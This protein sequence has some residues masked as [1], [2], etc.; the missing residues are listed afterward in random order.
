MY[1]E[2]PTEPVDK[3]DE[4]LVEDILEKRKRSEAHLAEWRKKAEIWYDMVAGK[5]WTAEDEAAHKDQRKPCVSFNRIAVMVNAI[6][7]SESNNRQEVQYKPRTIDDSGVNDLLT[8]G[9]KWARDQ[10]DAEDE[11]SD[12]FRDTTICGYGWTETKMD[13]ETNPEGMVEVPRRDPFAFHYDPAAVKRNLSDMQWVQCDDWLDDE[14]IL[15]RWPD[16]ELVGGQERLP[17]TTPHDASRAPWYEKTATDD[18]PDGTRCVIHHCWREKVTVWMVKQPPPPMPPPIPQLGGGMPPPNG[19]PGM[20]RPPMPQGVAGGMPAGPP[21]QPPGSMGGPPPPMGGMPPPMGMGG[22]PGMPP[23]V[24][25]MRPPPMGQPPM[26]PGPPGPTGAPPMGGMP[27]AGPPS[28]AGGPPG[29]PPMGMPPP[30]PPRPKK[31][32]DLEMSEE[33]YQLA[34][35]RTLQ[36]GLPPLKGRRRTKAVYKQAFL[37]GKQLLEVSDAP[38]QYEFIYQAITGYRDHLKGTF[39]GAV[40]VMEDP[41]RYANKMLSQLLHMI[42]T[43]AKGGILIEEGAVNDIRK[44][45]QDWA[46]TDGV[47]LVNAGALSGAKIQPKPIPQ[48]PKSI[49]EL[50]TFSVSSIRDASGVPLEMVGLADKMQPGI[51]EEARTNAG[52]GNVATLFDAL[53]HYRKA[54]GRLLAHFLI[55][56]MA[57]GRLVRVAGPLGERYEPLLLQRGVL[58]YDVVVDVAPTARDMKEKTFL[59]LMKIAPMVMQAGGP[60]PEEALDYAPLPAGLAESWKKQIAAAKQ[61]KSQQGD[62]Q[63]QMAQAVAQAEGAKAHT[64]EVRAQ[65]DIQLKQLE[66]QA[67]QAAQQTAAQMKQMEL[68][69]KKMDLQMAQQQ[70]QWK[71]EEHRMAMELQALKVQGE[72]QK[73]GVEMMKSAHEVQRMQAA[74]L[75]PTVQ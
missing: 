19:P 9:A 3:S 11:E 12:A 67:E 25:G 53:R 5:Q 24:P 15:G 70:A 35:E 30:P 74:P 64:A 20:P 51:V 14:A 65:A 2:Q 21:G 71:A 39:Y 63:V 41:Q 58:E 7:G 47:T 34:Q 16:A 10:C 68:E 54:Q 32:P 50:L 29:A 59:A 22:P 6:C 36:M 43:N 66:L 62:P 55:E 72:Q 38:C 48:Y 23:S 69:L 60:V 8:E 17:D 18:A 45:E 37:L 40:A 27:P 57:D 42:N 49:D 61:A 31:P 1:S 13:F 28:P 73:Q 4:E 52:M 46:K 26:P 33:D 75:A 56:Y 44:L